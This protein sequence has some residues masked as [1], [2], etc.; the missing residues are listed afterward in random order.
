M[1][2][3]REKATEEV[4]E[5]KGNQLDFG[6]KMLDCEFVMTSGP[7]VEMKKDEP[8]EEEFANFVASTDVP[9][10]HHDFGEFVDFKA[11]AF[12]A[13]PEFCS[14]KAFTCEKVNEESEEEMAGV[15]IT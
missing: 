10:K 2:D 5:S 8:E 1:G 11:S 3:R 15:T 6:A 9:Q 7:N 13:E 4:V 12:E 14:F